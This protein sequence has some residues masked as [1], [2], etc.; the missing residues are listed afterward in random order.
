MASH[1]D[2]QYQPVSNTETGTDD[3]LSVRVYTEMADALNNAHFHSSCHKVRSAV[4]FPAWSSW[5]AYTS[6]HVIAVFSP[7]SIPDGFSDLLWTIGHQRTS[8]A[9]SIVWS[10]KS[11]AKRYTGTIEVFNGAYLSTDAWTN[12]ITSTA[13]AHEVEHSTL[14]LPASLIAGGGDVHMVLTAQNSNGSTR[15]HI[16][17]LDVKPVLS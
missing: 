9:G 14:N 1:S 17:S 13:D 15:G 4:C 10:L 2:R 12:S 3:A 11:S 6:E 5:D 8:G 16:T 7:V